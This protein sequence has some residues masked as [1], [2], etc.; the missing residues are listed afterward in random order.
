MNDRK[1]K[2]LWT[3]TGDGCSTILRTDVQ[4]QVC[5]R[6]KRSTILIFSVSLCAHM[7]SGMKLN[8]AF[9]RSIWWLIVGMKPRE[10]SSQPSHSPTLPPDGPSRVRVPYHS[11]SVLIFH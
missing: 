9:W 3:L 4:E 7:N 11:P 6:V 8:L 2:I 10:A 5:S 1:Q